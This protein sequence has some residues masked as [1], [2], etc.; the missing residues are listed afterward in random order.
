METI[1][2]KNTEADRRSG[3]VSGK[4]DKSGNNTGTSSVN[5]SVVDP[6]NSPADHDHDHISFNED[7][8]SLPGS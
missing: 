2:M 5:R 8:E 7:L 1:T 4:N 3:A 6:E